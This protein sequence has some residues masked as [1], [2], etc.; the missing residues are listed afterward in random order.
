M[1]LRLRRI[2]A[3]AGSLLIPFI[4]LTNLLPPPAASLL[5][6]PLSVPAEPAQTLVAETFAAPFSRALATRKIEPGDFPLTGRD[7]AE[8]RREQREA[9]NINWTEVLAIVTIT[10]IF[11]TWLN[12]YLFASFK[13]AM[14]REYDERY[15][16]RS[17]AKFFERDLLRLEEDIA[18]LEGKTEP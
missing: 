2:A 12:K 10:S 17:E 18:R 1:K 16:A 3:A 9:Q 11:V 15:Q 5:A 7:W 13:N 8:W 6:I 4:L 14:S